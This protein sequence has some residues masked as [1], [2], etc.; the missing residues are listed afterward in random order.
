MQD[1]VKLARRGAILDIN[2]QTNLNARIIS[3][4]SK[5]EP[6]V[7]KKTDTIYAVPRNN[8]ADFQFDEQVAGV[9]PDMLQRSVPGYAM[10]I[11]TIGILAARYAQ[12]NSQCYDL[13]CSL[14]AVSLAMRQG[15]RQPD[16]AIIAVDNSRAMLDR[17]QKLLGEETTTVPIRMLCADLQ[18]VAIENASVVVL[19]LTL[20]FIPLAGR[21]PLLTRIHQGLKPGGILILSEKIA[22]EKPEHQ[23][24]H[25]ELHQDFKRAQGYSDLEIS[26][27]RT[28]LEKV[29]I[30][31]S[32]A[33]HQQR[34]QEAGFGFV[35]TWFQ[36]LN[37]V[38]L[39]AIK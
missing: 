15:I 11:S 23:Q 32:L 8:I 36:C 26:Q 39:V 33:C 34:L 14:G 22:F 3:P 21:L 31:E 24:F 30:P 2:P 12:A 27:K 25:V 35:D 28:A 7:T 20:Q 17:A 18:D 37:F 4:R 16:C 1:Q 19:N 13:G 10:M 6:L 9:F 5:D 38:S 29:M